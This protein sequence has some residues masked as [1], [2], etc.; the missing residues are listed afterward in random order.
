MVWNVTQD[1]ISMRMATFPDRVTPPATTE[2]YKKAPR[3]GEAKMSQYVMVGVWEDFTL[4]PLPA[5]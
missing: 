4:P 2:S 3:S 5:E 1:S